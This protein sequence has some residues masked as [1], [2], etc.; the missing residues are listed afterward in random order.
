[1]IVT[2]M[3][4]AGVLGQWDLKAAVKQQVAQRD[5]YSLSTAVSELN[6]AQISGSGALRGVAGQ[7]AAT[8]VTN[9][10]TVVIGG[11]YSHV[12]PIKDFK[13]CVVYLVSGLQV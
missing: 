12:T 10:G 7:E 13:G 9:P 4:L 11:D 1:M 8:L 3:A 2:A 6:V 5:V